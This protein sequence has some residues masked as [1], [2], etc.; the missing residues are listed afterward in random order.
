MAAYAN[1]IAP[2]TGI[3]LWGDCGA[4]EAHEN[5]PQVYVGLRGVGKRM[6]LFNRAW[7]ILDGSG[8]T[9][10]IVGPAIGIP[11]RNGHS[12]SGWKR[13]ASGPD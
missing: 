9:S 10:A 8:N 12:P 7:S 11:T 4:L 5:A 3:G 2:Q 13:I 1:R 6:L